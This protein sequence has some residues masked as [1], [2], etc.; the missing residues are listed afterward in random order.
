MR[1]LTAQMCSWLGGAYSQRTVP[2]LA[3]KAPTA[4]YR[5]RTSVSPTSQAPLP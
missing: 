2:I 3:S 4:S 1:R 5:L